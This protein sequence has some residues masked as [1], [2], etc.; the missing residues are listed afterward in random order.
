MVV[1][2]FR[3]FNCKHH[4]GGSADDDP[5]VG[6]ARDSAVDHGAEML[7]YSDRYF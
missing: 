6:V 5:V 7:G 1:Q 4:I 3:G 2:Q